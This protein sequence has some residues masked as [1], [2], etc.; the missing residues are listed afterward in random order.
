MP[1]EHIIYASSSAGGNTFEG[2]TIDRFTNR[3]NSPLSLNQYVQYEV[4]LTSILYPNNYYAVLSNDEKY[5]I[6]LL[7]N[8]K[9]KKRITH[10]YK[11]ICNRNIVA[12]DINHI[13][14]MLNDDFIKEIKVYLHHQYKKCIKDDVVIKW[15]SREKRVKLNYVE[16]SQN[17]KRGDAE[18]ISI[19]ISKDLCQLLGYRNDTSYE[20]YGQQK[21]NSIIGP[22]PPLPMCGVEYLYIYCDFVQPS[23]F[24]GQL[25]NILDCFT[26]QNGT[27][28]GIHNTIYK[29]MNSNFIEQISIIVTDQDGRRIHFYEGSSITCV[30][31]IRSK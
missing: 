13:V 20:I 27:N 25:V 22:F 19:H 7:V 10:S 18:K 29:D 12:G 4:G 3:L 1:E 26:F 2:N 31:H 11:Y 5:S 14:D 24:G 23:I 30:L 16:S 9:A 8:I 17:I 21:K 6:S 15:D 28:K